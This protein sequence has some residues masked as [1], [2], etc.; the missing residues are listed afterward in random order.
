MTL[1]ELFN[2]TSKILKNRKDNNMN[3]LSRILFLSLSL[4]LSCLANDNS[5]ILIPINNMFDAMRE[6]DS[7]KF[8]QQFT[9]G[10]ILERATKTNEIKQSDLTKFA[11]LID[12]STHY[13]DEQ[14]F[15][16]SIHQSGNVASVWT[17][18]AFYLDRKLSHCGINSFQLIKQSE[19]WK[20]RY[21]IDNAYQGNCQDFI[22]KHTR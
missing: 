10:A 16:I 9:T 22:N 19:Q 20:I 17:P 11:Q 18:F 21:L 5:E 2:L 13:L 8:S 15:N 12:K 3:K 14:L 4:P 7:K 6:H 1:I